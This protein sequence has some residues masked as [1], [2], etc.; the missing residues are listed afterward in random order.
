MPW[1]AAVSHTG[2]L[3]VACASVPT[4]SVSSR[5][6][7]P[8]PPSSFPS[9]WSPCTR[10][11]WRGRRAW[12][13]TPQAACCTSPTS[14]ST[15]HRRWRPCR[16]ARP[17]RWGGWVA[18]WV[19]GARCKA[20]CIKAWQPGKPRP[21]TLRHRGAHRALPCL[22]PCRQ[23][24][25]TCER[26]PALA[27]VVQKYGGMYYHFVEEALPRWVGVGWGGAGWT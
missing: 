1:H 12:C 26:H 11:L 27:S 22:S 20:A 5:Q 6:P 2:L 24:S 10:R 7:L 3:A 17:R 18:G 4:D 14:S 19:A 21:P 13:T 15:A 25:T 23:A 16:C 9:L 8:V